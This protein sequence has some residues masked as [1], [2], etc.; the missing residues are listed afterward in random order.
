MGSQSASKVKAA[1]DSGSNCPLHDCAVSV[2]VGELVSVVV[3]VG[4]VVGDVL[5]VVVGELIWV[6]VSEVLPVDEAV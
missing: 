6:L 1:Q 2:V 4:V 3:V 5:I